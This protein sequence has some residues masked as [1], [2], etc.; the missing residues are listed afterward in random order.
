M[1]GPLD[2]SWFITPSN[3]SYNYHKP[4]RYCSY[5]HQLNAIERGPHI[6]HHRGVGSP[7]PCYPLVA[8]ENVPI[9]PLA[10][11]W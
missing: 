10:I 5:V 8:M 4:K 1:W 7:S 6:V 11:L 9:W 3:Y 2:I